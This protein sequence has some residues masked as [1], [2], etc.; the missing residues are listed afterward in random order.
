[1]RRILFVLFISI[2]PFITLWQDT[3]IV[4]D[5]DNDNST[6]NN[7][8]SDTTNT[9]STSAWLESISFG[10]CNEWI[11]NLST[12]LN[13]AVNV[14]EPTKICSIF[15]NK[16]DQDITIRVELVDWWT[17]AEWS[18]TCNF[19]SKNI[20]K[21]I[22]EDVLSELEEFIIPAW[23]YVIKEFEITFPIGFE[24]NQSACYTYYVPS[25]SQW[26]TISTVISNWSFMDFFV[27]W[28]ENIKNEIT[29]SDTK[30]YL[31]DNK[32]LVLDF[33]LSNI[34]NLED[35]IVIQWKITNIFWF[36][37]EFNI[38]WKWIQL[39]PGSS[40]PVSATLWS[41][42]NYGWLFNIEF[43]VTSTPFFSYDISQSSIDPALLE[44]KT[45]TVNTTYF[46]MPWL[47][48]IVVVMFIIILYLLF[49]KPKKS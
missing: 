22:N 19:A 7:T 46:Q 40:T 16:S 17:S 31:N 6:I 10:F 8:I 28:L 49:R 5:S 11:D 48:F 41:I 2:I 38:E 20:Q 34:W 30:T 44:D 29:V 37:K 24:W 43:T 23:Q 15:Q 26:S 9:S 33:L 14:W 3:D 18:K 4:N 39:T 36:K 42:P 47:I 13:Y 21:F 12:N 32:D 35:T 25:K 1:M 45:F 27:W